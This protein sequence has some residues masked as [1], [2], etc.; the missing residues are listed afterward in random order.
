MNIKYKASSV[1]YGVSSEQ[2]FD[3]KEDLLNM[4]DFAEDLVI[5]EIDVDDRDYILRDV[6]EELKGVFSWNAY[7]RG[8]SAGESEVAS[9]MRSLV[10]DFLPA[11]LAY[12]I[13]MKKEK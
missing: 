4:Y 9:C 8:H 11:I 13:R 6:P 2:L 5:Q 1:I 7:E 12:G 3:T 10:Y